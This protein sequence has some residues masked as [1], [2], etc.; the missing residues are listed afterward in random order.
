MEYL[1]SMS[2]FIALH[3]LLD[4]DCILILKTLLITFG[5]T[6][7]FCAHAQEYKGNLFTESDYFCQYFFSQKD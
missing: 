3:L 5:T 6:N 2:N 1:R 4:F 7:Q